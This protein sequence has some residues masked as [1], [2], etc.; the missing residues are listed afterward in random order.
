MGPHL[1]LCLL[2]AVVRSYPPRRNVPMFR[3]PTRTS[4]PGDG[5]GPP[6]WP[7]SFT[8]TL[9][10]GQE[11]KGPSHTAQYGTG[12]TRGGN[13]PPPDVVTVAD[14]GLT[15]NSAPS[16]LGPRLSW[17][18][19]PRANM[20]ASQLGTEMSSAQDNSAQSSRPHHIGN[21]NKFLSF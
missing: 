9:T 3:T 19:R 5:T 6:G 14:Y 1:R 10:A 15:V 2:L 12:E 13:S 17:S 16:Q 21:A 7:Y 4:C 11:G 18:T 20:A 8:R